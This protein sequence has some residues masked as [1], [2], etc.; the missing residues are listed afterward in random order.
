[1][2]RK[3]ASQGTE[4][5]SRRE[6]AAFLGILEQTLAVWACTKRYNL[7]V[8]KVGRL[9]KYRRSDLER[10]INGETNFEASA[11]TPD[12]RTAGFAEVRIVEERTKPVQ[13]STAVAAPL[14]ISLPGGVTLRVEPGCSMQLLATV[15]Q[16]MENR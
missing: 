12:S 15:V 6:A 10:F 5:L 2:A 7:P 8:V 4:L 13:E 1:M 14:E 9:C 11:A 3:K 16:M